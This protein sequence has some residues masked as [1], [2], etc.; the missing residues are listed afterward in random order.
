MVAAGIDGFDMKE[1]M[2]D[3]RNRDDQRDSMMFSWC[4]RAQ[5]PEPIEPLPARTAPPTAPVLVDL[6][7][8]ETSDDERNEEPDRK[9]VSYQIAEHYDELNA[10]GYALA[11][12]ACL[13]QS[14]P[15]M[16]D[17]ERS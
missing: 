13:L 6:E 1:A 2:C 10:M 16:L 5:T 12:S 15:L 4:Y 8:D 14:F 11:T 9:D 3:V 7:P 17:P